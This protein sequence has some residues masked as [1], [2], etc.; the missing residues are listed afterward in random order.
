[1]IYVINDYHFKVLNSGHKLIFSSSW[2]L[3]HLKTGGDWVDYYMADPREMVISKGGNT[4]LVNNIVGG[5]AC[6][7]GE[8][9]DDTNVISRVWP[10]AS[11]T[12]E[13]L[14]SAP[15][16]S[17]QVH[18]QNDTSED[19]NAPAQEDQLY[20]VRRRLEEHTCRMRRRG[21]PAQPPNGPG[22]CIG[23]V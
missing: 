15:M 4:S 9:V 22:Y 18:N 20:E 21:I 13:R 5:E 8:V 3:D 14:W 17:V 19:S 2:Y 7:W 11:A 16:D 10:R 6:M 12:A 23:A 1:S